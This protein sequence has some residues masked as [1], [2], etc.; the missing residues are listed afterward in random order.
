MLDTKRIKQDFPILYD[1][2]ICYLDNAATSQKPRQVIESIENYYF[3]QNANPHRSAHSLGQAATEAFENSRHK[4]RKFIGAKSDSEIIFT[5]SAT[6]SLN[7]IANGIGKKFLRPGNEVL[8]SIQE[9][10]ANLIPWQFA[11]KRS[12]SKLVYAYLNEDLSLNCEELLS[13]INKNTKVISLT[14]ASNVTGSITDLYSL[15]KDI[16]KRTNAVVIVDGCQSLPHIKVDVAEMDCD[17][18][19]ASGHKLLAPMGIGLLYGK[20][21]VLNQLCPHLFGGDMIEYVFEQEASFLDAPFKFEA[22][23]QNVSGAVGFA[24]AID[25]LEK[26]GMDNVHKHETE[27]IDYAYE[28]FSRMKDILL[29]TTRKD[30]TAVLSFN[31]DNAHPHDIATILDS[32]GIMIR[33]GHHCA[34]PLHRYLKRPFSARASFYIYNSLDDVDRLIEGMQK[35]RR[36]LKLGT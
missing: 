32:E 12:S 27:L 3:S 4:I 7:I 19:V 13:M 21:E 20:F 17:F 10:H 35:V 36:I 28:K 6:E 22:G 25:Y 33:S 1:E 30:K 15:I 24:S 18:F 29:Y 23:T 34:Q 8:I 26:L 5:K 2:K 14:Q 16:R 31:D 9:H 11:C